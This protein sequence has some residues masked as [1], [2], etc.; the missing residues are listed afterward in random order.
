MMGKQEFIALSRTTLTHD[1]DDPSW[2]P[3]TR[4]FVTS[5]PERRAYIENNY[6]AGKVMK[7]P[8]NIRSTFIGSYTWHGLY[9]LQEPYNPHRLW[10][11]YNVLLIERKN[12]IAYRQGIAGDYVNS[13]CKNLQ[14]LDLNHALQ[15]IPS[16]TLL[17]HLPSTN[18]MLDGNQADVLRKGCTG[19]QPGQASTLNTEH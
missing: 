2:D 10:P 16:I 18:G 6:H 4:K 5:V 15:A 1:I 7:Y 14:D 17:Q 8:E 11:F 3:C 13:Y 9:E 19:L 12:G